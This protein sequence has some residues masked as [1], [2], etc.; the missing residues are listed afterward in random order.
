MAPSEWTASVRAVRDTP[1]V[2]YSTPGVN[3]MLRF[4]YRLPTAVSQSLRVLSVS[5]FKQ[6]LWRCGQLWQYVGMGSLGTHLRRDC[7]AM[8]DAV[9]ISPHITSI[10]TK[11]AIRSLII[12]HIIASRQMNVAID[13]SSLVPSVTCVTTSSYPWNYVHAAHNISHPENFQSNSCQWLSHLY[14]FRDQIQVT[15]VFRYCGECQG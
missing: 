3:T 6:S 4:V 1:A 8:G 10:C 2:H 11:N 12:I 15:R 7:N 9:N 14:K 5:Y 13:N